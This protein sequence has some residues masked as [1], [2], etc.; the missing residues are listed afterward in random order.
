MEISKVKIDV[1]I[2]TTMAPVL[3]QKRIMIRDI[4][5]HLDWDKGINPDLSIRQN[6]DHLR[7]D[8]CVIQTL[9]FRVIKNEDGSKFFQPIIEG[10]IWKDYKEEIK[11]G[12]AIENYF[13][14]P[15]WG[16]YFDF[17]K[18]MNWVTKAFLRNLNISF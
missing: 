13:N 2:L 17:V 11:N 9:R 12:S 10:M 16:M 5:H 15:T 3:A 7:S 18:P 8:G 1:T 4:D 14:Y 6:M